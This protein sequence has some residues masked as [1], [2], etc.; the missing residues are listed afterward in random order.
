M[1]FE[2]EYFNATNVDTISATKIM[3]FYRI[4]LE[5]QINLRISVKIG[6]LNKYKQIRD[7]ANNE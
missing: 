1:R 3:L 5:T 6:F 2:R 7:K 4:S